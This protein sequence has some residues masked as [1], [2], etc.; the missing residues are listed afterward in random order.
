MNKKLENSKVENVDWDVVNDFGTEWEEFQF[1]SYDLDILKETWNQYFDIFPWD[2]ISDDAEGFDMGCGSGRWAQFVIPKVGRLNCIDPSSA[3][4]V[5]ESNLKQ[6]DNAFFYKETVDECSLD[7]ESQDFGYSLGVLHHI[8]DTQKALK[9]C[10]CKLKK[11]APFL[12]YLYYDFEDKPA[13]FKLIWKLTDILRSGLISKL[14]PKIKKFVCSVIAVM[15][16][17]PLA[18]FSRILEILGINVEN[19]PL[20]DYRN[21]SFYIMNN[22]ALDRFGTK[23][24][25]RFSKKDI[26]DM[27]RNA[28]FNKVTFSKSTPYW[29]CISYKA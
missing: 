9:D 25:Q 28:G 17:Y 23:L 20:S 2:D 4:H 7:N 29:T 1:D 22:D 16:Y 26:T 3:I 5:A 11:G 19:L 18:K 14:P 24:E 27:L 15:I 8:P 21:K 13:I 10:A 12:L 6:H